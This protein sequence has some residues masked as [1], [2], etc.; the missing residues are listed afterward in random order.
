MITTS[1]ESKKIPNCYKTCWIWDVYKLIYPPDIQ[2]RL[3]AVRKTWGIWKD[4]PQE[5]W[6]EYE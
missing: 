3:E 1:E 6:D 2:A 5:A 4:I